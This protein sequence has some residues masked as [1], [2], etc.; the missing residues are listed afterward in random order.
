MRSPNVLD[1]SHQTI[2]QLTMLETP[3]QT[4]QLGHAHVLAKEDA[5]LYAAHALYKIIFLFEGLEFWVGQA[6]ETT[7]QIEVT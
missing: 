5:I 6:H 4:E 2:F 3:C 7:N 1:Q